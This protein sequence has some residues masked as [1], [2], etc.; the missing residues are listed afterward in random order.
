[1]H[2]NSQLF[3]SIAGDSATKWTGGC[4]TVYTF[5]ETTSELSQPG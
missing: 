3:C 1:M 5:R 4:N 2:G